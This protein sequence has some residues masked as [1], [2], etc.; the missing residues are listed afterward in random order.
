MNAS[1]EAENMTVAKGDWL[2]GDWGHAP[3]R[4]AATVANTFMSR[5]SCL[6]APATVGAESVA[7]A[8]FK[9][10]TAASYNVLLRYEAAYLFETPVL[11]EI[12]P[13]SGG[14]PVFSKIYGLR[15]SLKVQ[16]FGKARLLN[17]TEY[18]K[19]G[20][21]CGQ[22]RIPT[23]GLQ[24]ECIWPYGA[25]ENW[26]W[27]GVGAMAQ[28]EAGEYTIAMT[29][30]NTTTSD[31]GIPKDLVAFAERN[32]DAILLTTNSSDVKK[33]LWYASDAL[34][35]D[36]Y[37]SQAGEVFFRVTNL[38]SQNNLTLTVPRVYGHSYYFTMQYAVHCTHPSN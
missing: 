24:A 8:N 25:T 6:H 7:T 12:R 27:E 33:R 37:L 21:M 2:A 18:S 35:L 34:A 14:R 11:L 28:L 1:I 32:I 31:T 15:H 29:G 13:S 16:G 30:V 22:G 5:R 4:F 17:A 38:D 20:S 19:S 10:A 36:G 3:T 9:V 23:N 26:V